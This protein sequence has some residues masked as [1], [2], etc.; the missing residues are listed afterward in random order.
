MSTSGSGSMTPISTGGPVSGAILQPLPYT[1]LS[2]WRYARIMGINP[3]HFAGA[4]TASL[5]RQVYYSG[6]CDD[7]WYKYDWQA[8]D[9]VSHMQLA[10][11][12]ATAEA[13]IA[14]FLGS[15]VAP[16]W[17]NEEA[18]VYPRPYRAAYYGTG[19]ATR[20]LKMIKTRYG[21]LISIGRRST[22]LIGT[23]IT[24]GSSLQYIDNDGDGFAELARVSV[25]TTL[26]DVSQI[27]VYYPGF[28]ADP[29][30]EI[31]DAI[32]KEIASG[33]FVAYFHSWNLIAPELYDQPP[34]DGDRPPIDVGTTA[35]FLT[36]VEVYREF[37]DNTLPGVTFYW[38]N[39]GD[40]L[41]TPCQDS[42]QGGCAQIKDA[43]RG[44]VSPYPASYDSSSG[45]WV[46][47]G[48]SEGHEPDRLTIS[49]QAGFRSSTFL[50]G[51]DTE[52]LD[53]NLA[54]A[55]A[56]LAT[57]RLERPLC[58]CSNV[59]ALAQRLMSDTSEVWSDRRFIVFGRDA[60]DCPFG[61]KVGEIMAWRHIKNFAREVAS[62]I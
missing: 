58:G 4:H 33:Y 7:I 11:Q 54:Q 60:A 27:K 52:P 36:T 61:S 48:W 25:P 15:F 5:G 21:E 53:G 31:R 20:D 50:A 23:A 56:Y 47:E 28:G 57:A 17:V 41:D 44:I 55:V 12:I 1:S 19:R 30:W 46:A 10:I 18:H 16:R 24:S 42:A 3:L 51:F 13:Q 26:T 35:N 8:A 38:S 29:R 39:Y 40:C 34:V 62:A 49:Y 37:S 6:G 22:V 59:E 9:K 45:A 2:I 32:K 14:N 43:R